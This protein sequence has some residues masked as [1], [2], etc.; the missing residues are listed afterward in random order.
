[1][2]NTA[3]GAKDKVASKKVLM[4]IEQYTKITDTVKKS[5]DDA[6]KIVTESAARNTKEAVFER[7][8]GRIYEV[9]SITVF[10]VPCL[11]KL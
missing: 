6:D 1:M 5:L 11:N 4:D 2:K 8:R 10:L 7:A 9:K 3:T